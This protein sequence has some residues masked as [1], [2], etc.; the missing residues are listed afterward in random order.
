MVFQAGRSDFL[1]SDF[2]SCLS[3][4]WYL[5]FLYTDPERF[6]SKAA[7]SSSACLKILSGK[8]VSRSR[9]AALRAFKVSALTPAL[10]YDR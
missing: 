9:G 6:L 8:R 5:P 7:M 2:L 3:Y 4:G 1:M 10:R